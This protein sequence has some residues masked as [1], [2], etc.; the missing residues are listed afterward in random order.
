TVHTSTG[1][2]PF[3][4]IEGHPKPLPI[5]K[6][7]QKIFAADEYARDVNIAFQKIK[8]A[9]QASQQKQ[10]RAADKHKRPLEFKE[11]DWVLLKFPK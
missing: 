11:N 6:M 8:E 7:H 3:K 10:K 5:L 2:A 4:I 9:V 1:K